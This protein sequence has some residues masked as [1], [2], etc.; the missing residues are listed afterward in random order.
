M[1][2]LFWCDFTRFKRLDELAEKIAPN[3]Q[4]AIYTHID[5]DH[6]H[7]HIVI[8]SVDLETGKKYQSNKKQRELV[9]EANDV[10]GFFN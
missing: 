7:N 6:Y 1:I 5:K 8:N 4:V 10:I 3:H 9:K 2:T